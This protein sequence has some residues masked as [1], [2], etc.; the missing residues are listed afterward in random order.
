M[1]TKCRPKSCLERYHC[2]RMLIKS[3][4]EVREDDG[5][6]VDLEQVFREVVQLGKLEY[7]K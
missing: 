2:T 7:P 4:T 3:G 6:G 1:G 5:E